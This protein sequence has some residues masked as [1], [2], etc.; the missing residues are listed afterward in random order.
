MSDLYTCSMATSDSVR[1]KKDCKDFL[2]LNDGT[3]TKDCKYCDLS[4]E[5]RQIDIVD[6][7][8]VPME[9]HYCPVVNPSTGEVV[10]WEYYCTGKHDIRPKKE[11]IED[12]KVS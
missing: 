7:Q 4:R 10:E 2:C 9:S 1:Y 3:I 12:D 6:G 8:P 5:C 11:R